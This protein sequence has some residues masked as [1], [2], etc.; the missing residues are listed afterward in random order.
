MTNAVFSIIL[1]P[2]SRICG[3]TN[4]VINMEISVPRPRHFPIPKIATS[5]VIFPI[6]IPDIASIVPEVT[7][8]GK[9]WFIVSMIDCFLPDSLRSSV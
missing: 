7:M 4:I 3:S 9:D 5:D 2:T 6:R 8:V 1:S